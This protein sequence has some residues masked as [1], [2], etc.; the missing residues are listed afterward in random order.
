M[1]RN[2]FL[3]SEI[4]VGDP[5]C[6]REKQLT[7]FVA[8]ARAQTN[9]VL[10]S[11][12]R[13]G[14]TSLIKRVQH[15]LQGEGFLT[16]YCDLF[17]V[18]SIEE[19]AGRITRSIFSITQAKESLFKKA[20]SLIR[21]F[22][23]VI[24]MNEKGEMSVSV[25]PAFKKAGLGTLEETLYGLSEFIKTIDPPTH[26]VFDEF[27]E[28]NEIE[29]SV[30][31]EGILRKHIQQVRGSFVFVGSR[32]RLLLEMFNDRKR[33]FFQSVVNYE[34]EP[35]PVD[36]LTAFIVDQF[37]KGNKHISRP[38]AE[39]IAN[40]VNQHPGYTQKL[41]FF[42][43][44]ICDNQVAD[45]DLIEAY[46][47]LI[48]NEKHYFESILQGLS[49][50]QVSLLLAIAKE[51]EGKVYSADFMARHNLGSTGGIQNSL[52]V[53]LRQDI[54]EQAVSSKTWSVVD[55]LLTSWLL[56]LSI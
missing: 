6:D 11:P 55:P 20:I 35:L 18:I 49:N 8:Y 43:Y 4:P 7:D 12:R 24:G 30:A 50:K 41:C 22:R 15:Q 47:M 46:E 31:I 13:F 44:E 16:A 33:P 51:S 38:Q 32:R 17:G 9:A 39:K 28:L 42:L 25:Q 53:L 29:N 10:F 26:L 45:S 23:P 52:A 54:I 19:I 34:L 27:Q 3:L 1:N 37:S 14:K 36:E 21:S 5:F 2:P 48:T 40:R 56:R